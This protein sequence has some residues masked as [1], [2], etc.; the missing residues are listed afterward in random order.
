MVAVL[1]ST[2]Q[3]WELLLQSRPVFGMTNTIDNR[4]VDCVGFG[5]DRAPDGEQ[6]RDGGR[7]QDTGVVDD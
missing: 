7:F 1:R 3:A 5:E 2:R 6:G 4:I